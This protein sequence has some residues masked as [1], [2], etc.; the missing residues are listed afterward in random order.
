[1]KAIEWLDDFIRHTPFGQFVKVLLYVA[2]SIGCSLILIAYLNLDVPQFIL[3][4]FVVAPAIYML[5][6]RGD[7]PFWIWLILF[8]RWYVGI[9]SGI[10]AF[11]LAS[12][13][14]LDV[15]LPPPEDM[16]H[17]DGRLL[18]FISN[19]FNVSYA[20]GFGLS[21]LAGITAILAFFLV[22][23]SPSQRENP[24]KRFWGN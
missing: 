18:I 19:L 2:L 5:G 8:S 11:L 9:L 13:I 17:L 22:P 3:G 23:T 24:H 16:N 15:P 7:R 12:I 20:S 21:I 14:F 1:M 10:V 6:I 4:E